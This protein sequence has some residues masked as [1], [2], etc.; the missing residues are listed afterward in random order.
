[1]TNIIIE[2]QSCQSSEGSDFWLIGIP[3]NKNHPAE[4]LNCRIVF[5][6]LMNEF[7]LLYLVQYLVFQRENIPQLRRHLAPRWISL[8]NV[9]LSLTGVWWGSSKP[10]SREATEHRSRQRIGAM[11]S[12]CSSLGFLSRRGPAGLW[13]RNSKFS[14]QKLVE[15]IETPLSLQRKFSQLIGLPNLSNSSQNLSFNWRDF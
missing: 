14:P 15:K 6:S 8:W 11:Q 5:S 13:E 2:H 12:V 4:L 1:M 7:L 3:L 9:G 10:G